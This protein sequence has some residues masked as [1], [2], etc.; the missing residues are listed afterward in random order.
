[1]SI[2]LAE[3][4]SNPCLFLV[5]DRSAPSKAKGAKKLSRGRPPCFSWRVVCKRQ[6]ETTATFNRSMCKCLMPL[7]RKAN[8]PI[9]INSINSL[10]HKSK[11]NKQVTSSKRID[12]SDSNA[13]TFCEGSTRCCRGE[14]LKI[15]T[16]VKFIDCGHRN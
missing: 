15:E 8:L 2:I 14:G 1:M 3:A 12:P 6:G 16:L 11:R 10:E 4:R 13:L 5:G 9:I 7:A